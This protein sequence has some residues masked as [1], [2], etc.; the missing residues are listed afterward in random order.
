[1]HACF[2]ELMYVR[3]CDYVRLAFASSMDRGNRTND[4]KTIGNDPLE[5]TCDASAAWLRIAAFA[6][7]DTHIGVSV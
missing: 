7:G 4:G 6:A 2:E 1:M 5:K 3:S